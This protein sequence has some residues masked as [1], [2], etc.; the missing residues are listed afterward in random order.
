MYTYT[1]K[2]ELTTYQKGKS[3]LNSWY[4]IS[5]S[6]CCKEYSYKTYASCTWFIIMVFILFD[7][8]LN[9]PVNNFQL[10]RRIQ[11]RLRLRCADP[12]RGWQRVLTPSLEIRNLWGSLAILVQIPWKTKSYKASIP[13]WVIIVPPAFCCWAGDGPLLVVF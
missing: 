3:L 8:I 10:H 4:F 5:L 9:I 1:F 2:N 11:L 12:E 6:Q 7:F 13:Y